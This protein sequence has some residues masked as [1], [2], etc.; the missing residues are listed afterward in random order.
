LYKNASVLILDEATSALDQQTEAAVMEE[1]ANLDRELTL[2]SIAHRLTTV[3]GC[4]RIYRLEAGRIVQAGTYDEV[5]MG[6]KNVASR[7]SVRL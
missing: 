6:P 1:F 2:I 3:A 7:H 4:D 5:V